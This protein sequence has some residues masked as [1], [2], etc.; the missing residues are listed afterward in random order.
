[1]RVRPGEAEQEGAAVTGAAPLQHQVA[2]HPPGTLAA[3]VEAQPGP[4]GSSRPR[5]PDESLEDPLPILLGNTRSVVGHPDLDGTRGGADRHRHRR[6]RV[7]VDQRVVDKVVHD[8][9]HQVGVS[10]GPGIGRAVEAQ[11][12]A[13]QVEARAHPVADGVEEGGEGDL[14]TVDAQLVGLQTGHGEQRGG[15]LLSL[16]GLGGDHP[17]RFE[18]C[19]PKLSEVASVEERG[20]TLDHRERR[21]QLVDGDVEQIRPGPFHGH[22]QRVRG[23]AV[24]SRGR[25]GSVRRH[26][27]IGP[28]PQRA[29]P[30]RFG[31][32]KLS[33]HTRN[34][35]H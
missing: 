6:R 11:G 34:I 23:P 21:A 16:V 17:H 7:G 12:P 8:P 19:L 26:R 15:Q 28:P 4:G 29:P 13:T 14:L 35:A 20:V 10:Q 32:W 22:G 33:V 18:R 24:L 9:G 31:S 30:R 5:P 3:H 1:M 25:G 27:G 2:P